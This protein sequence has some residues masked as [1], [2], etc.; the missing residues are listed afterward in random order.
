MINYQIWL[1]VFEN[2]SKGKREAPK[3]QAFGNLFAIAKDSGPL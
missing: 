3:D 2:S 1:V